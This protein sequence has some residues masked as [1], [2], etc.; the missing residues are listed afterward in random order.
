MHERYMLLT[1]GKKRGGGGGYVTLREILCEQR[2]L[3]VAVT[4][5][6]CRC[7]YVI[8]SKYV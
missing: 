6:L 8:V 5:F 3:L 1:V 4:N 2:H 7:L